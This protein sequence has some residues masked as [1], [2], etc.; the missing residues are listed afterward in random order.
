MKAVIWTAY[1][2]PEV[3]QLRDVPIPVLKDNQVL[4]KVAVSN[5]F[6]GDCELR[7]FDVGFPFNIPVRLFVGLF[8]PRKNSVLGQ[9]YAG[10]V[11]AVGKGITSFKPGER[12]FGC[13][14]PFVTGSY[15][16]YLVSYGKVLARLP[17]N[18][19]FE[20]GAVATVGGLNAL[21]F[22]RV[23]GIR[24][25][26]PA[27]KV[28]II[29][30][31][32]SIGTMAVQIA[33]LFGSHVA[34]VDSTAKLERLRQLGADRVFDFTCEDFVSVGETYD[35]V[36]DIVGRNARTN[37]FLKSLSVVKPGGRLILGNPSFRH[38][39]LRFVACWFT[40]KKIRFALA[41][42]PLPVVEY[43][44]RLLGSGQVK[45]LV[46]RRFALKDAVDAHIYVES[47]ARIGNVVLQI[48]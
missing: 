15:Q 21:H 11:E 18:V 36:I 27:Q 33:K 7:R 34:V 38:L 24:E 42:Y 23:A 12:V 29:G 48:D 46:D 32:G 9:E 4:V 10:V 43:L 3:L 6:P 39:L 37:A 25:G 40:R 28:L 17:D 5:V 26:A 13:V 8:K 45:P 31:G 2:P 22:L 1:G 35:T 19:S 44:A 30:A 47:G 20:A 14:E 41:G 16:E